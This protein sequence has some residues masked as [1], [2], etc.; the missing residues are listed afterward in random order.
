MTCPTCGQPVV[1]TRCGIKLTP[2]KVRIFDLI[3]RSGEEGIPST[4]LNILVFDGMA[5]PNTVKAHIWQINNVIEDEGWRI[6]QTVPRGG[7]CLYRLEQRTENG[8]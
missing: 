4:A 5:S 1:E 7:Y 3:Q 2:I 8:K 6:R